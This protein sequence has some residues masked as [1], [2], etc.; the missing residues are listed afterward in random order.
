MSRF[1][2]Y[3]QLKFLKITENIPSIPLFPDSCLGLIYYLTQLIACI[4]QLQ[5]YDVK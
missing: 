2:A 5:Y 4:R 1:K 3:F